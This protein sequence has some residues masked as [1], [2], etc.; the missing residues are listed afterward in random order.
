MHTRQFIRHPVTMPIEASRSTPHG[1]V[2][3]M[4]AYSIGI[5][6]LAFRCS[7]SLAPG[8]L[9]HIRI[10]HVRP[11]FQTDARVV[12]CL[13][14]EGGAELGVE[15]LNADDAFRARMVEQV[16]HIERYRQD[17]HDTQGRILTPEEAAAEWI[18]RFAATFPDPDSA[19]DR[20]G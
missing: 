11:E 3:A 18:D 13:D 6:G 2:P 14:S 17:V 15:F 8:T 7:Q 9:V 1:P 4:H 5:G 12:W 19:L 20:R 16:C 10:P